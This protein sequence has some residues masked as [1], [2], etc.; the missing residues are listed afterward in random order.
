MLLL[1][2]FTDIGSSFFRKTIMESLRLVR[3]TDYQHN[4]KF[5]F[6][7]SL[8]NNLS[9]FLLAIFICMYTLKFE[10]MLEYY[11][12]FQPMFLNVVVSSLLLAI[13]FNIDITK[14]I[15]VLPTKPKFF[16]RFY[17]LINGLAI[18]THLLY[19]ISNDIVAIVYIATT[20]LALA[21]FYN[22]NLIIISWQYLSA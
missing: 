12:T 22:I 15:I 5:L 11:Q 16:I 8:L 13:I 10:S 4:E 7:I 17:F 19:F 6:I 21:I 14:Q 18:A 3:K 1:N 20:T 9:L 2:K